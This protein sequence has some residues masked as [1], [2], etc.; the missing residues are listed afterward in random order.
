MIFT[1]HM[2]I[3]RTASVCFVSSRL[4][5]RDI[6]LIYRACFVSSSDLI[7]LYIQRDK[8]SGNIT[9]EFARHNFGRGD[10]RA[11]WAVTVGRSKNSANKKIYIEY[12]HIYTYFTTLSYN[13]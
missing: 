12:I 11:T 2:P 7:P 5:E 1:R 3:V 4:I 8:I 13:Y 6:L 10:F 9:Q